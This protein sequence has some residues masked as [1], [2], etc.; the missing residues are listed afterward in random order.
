MWCHATCYNVEPHNP[1]TI[2]KWSKCR[3]LSKWSTPSPHKKWFQCSCFYPADGD[4]KYSGTL[5]PTFRGTKLLIP[6]DC[7]PH[8]LHCEHLKCYLPFHWLEL[9]R[10]LCSLHT[11]ML[12]LLWSHKL[13]ETSSWFHSDTETPLNVQNPRIKIYITVE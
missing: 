6:E 13:F 7:N 5:V 3:F 1:R 9:E 8:N 2:L 11:P 12:C 4:S 10:T